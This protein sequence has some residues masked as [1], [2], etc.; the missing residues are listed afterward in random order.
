MDE[1]PKN[2]QNTRN[3][4]RDRRE[5]VGDEVVR[6]EPF[7]VVETVA[8]PQ[9]SGIV[10]PLKEE[11]QKH[12]A[13]EGKSIEKNIDELLQ[14]EQTYDPNFFE[15]EWDKKKP[16]VRQRRDGA[17]VVEARAQLLEGA[18]RVGTRRQERRRVVLGD[19]VELGLEGAEGAREDDPGEQDDPLGAAAGDDAGEGLHG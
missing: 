2:S 4:S 12:A 15:K 16:I 19:R 5:G 18:R 13:Y 6:L 14:P 17:P 8:P 1:R 7:R 9:K 11:T 3:G 10:L